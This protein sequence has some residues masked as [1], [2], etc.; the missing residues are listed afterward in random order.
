MRKIIFC[1][2]LL[3]AAVGCQSLAN[4]VVTLSS[5]ER[6]QAQSIAERRQKINFA[7]QEAQNEFREKLNR[8]DEQESS[9]NVE[10]SK[11]CFSFKKAHKLPPNV[12]YIL[13]EW[14]GQL[15]KQ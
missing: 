3:F 4:G 13:D 10:A 2:I 6:T 15:V 5:D 8:L 14:N 7:R 1:G 11:L 12:N 9:L